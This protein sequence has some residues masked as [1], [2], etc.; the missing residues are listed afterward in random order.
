M[1][2][3]EWE[4][5]VPEQTLALTYE[6]ALDLGEVLAEVMR[7]PWNFRRSADE[8][9]GSHFAHRTVYFADGRGMLTFLFLEHAVEV[10]ITGITWLG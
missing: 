1:Y 10:H 4:P 5:G 3:I 8:P 9:V 2:S 6:A 7:D